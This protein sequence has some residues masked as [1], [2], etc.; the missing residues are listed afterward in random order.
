ME[1]FGATN[2]HVQRAA[3][4]WNMYS[5]VEYVDEG[6]SRRCFLI[7][8]VPFLSE[9]CFPILHDLE[10]AWVLVLLGRARRISYQYFGKRLAVFI[11]AFEKSEILVASCSIGTSSWYTHDGPFLQTKSDDTR[12]PHVSYTHKL[13]SSLF[14]LSNEMVQTT[15]LT[16]VHAHHVQIHVVLS[17]APP[18]IVW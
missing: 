6:P 12:L 17:H 16:I 11:C 3:R 1:E 10:K 15:L 4:L 14:S 13:Q 5:V 2:Q 8:G 7:R 9:T 18:A